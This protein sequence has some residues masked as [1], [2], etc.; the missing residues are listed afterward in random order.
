MAS[1]HGDIF[2]AKKSNKP[3]NEVG[4]GLNRY[5]PI[6]HYFCVFAGSQSFTGDLGKTAQDVPVSIQSPTYYCHM[7]RQN[8]FE[9]L[10]LPIITKRM[11]ESDN[12]VEPPHQVKQRFCNEAGDKDVAIDGKSLKKS[13]SAWSLHDYLC[14]ARGKMFTQCY[15]LHKHRK[16]HCKMLETE[17]MPKENYYSYQTTLLKP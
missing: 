6:F 15:S 17:K 16:Y 14:E 8:S 3:T 9:H 11:P 12:P 10:Q 13:P 1:N 4:G 2:S 7:P 5:W